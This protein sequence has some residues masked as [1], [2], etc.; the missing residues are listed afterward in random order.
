MRIDR[1]SW[2]RGFIIVSAVALSVVSYAGAVFAATKLWEC[3]FCHQQY[4]GDFVPG[5][6]RTAKCPAKDMK[7]NHFWIQKR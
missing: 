1:R 7:Q 5:Q 6:L 3:N 2:F 4:Q